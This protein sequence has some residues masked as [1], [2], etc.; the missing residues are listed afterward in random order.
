MTKQQA[1]DCEE[2]WDISNGAPL[3]SKCHNIFHKIYGKHNFTEKDFE[4]W[5][6]SDNLG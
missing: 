1:L 2:L 4:E 6:I 3:C 5:F